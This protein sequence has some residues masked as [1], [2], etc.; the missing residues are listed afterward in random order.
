M[1]E[2]STGNDGVITSSTYVGDLKK[3]DSSADALSEI[4]T[5][6][7]YSTLSSY[8]S[9]REKDTRFETMAHVDVLVTDYSSI[10][11]DFL[12]VDKPIIFIP[13]DLKEYQSYRGFLFDYDCNTP[14]DKV[15]T[16]EAFIES[17][18][19]SL[20]SPEQYSAERR[21]VLDLFHKYQHGNSSSRILAKINEI[22]S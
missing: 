17:L 1:A 18:D 20:N 7:F 3:P 2:Y 15:F 10:Y 19:S 16:Q 5:E 12:L 22:N 21:V 4:Q 14:G 11:L 8:Y 13:Y 9:Y 6:N